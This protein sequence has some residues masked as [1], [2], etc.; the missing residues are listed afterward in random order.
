MGALALGAAKQAIKPTID[1]LKFQ[2][3][4]RDSVVISRRVPSASL[5]EMDDAT[6]LLETCSAPFTLI[7]A[8]HA[9]RRFAQAL[10]ILVAILAID[11]VRRF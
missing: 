11:A 7:A 10:T 6:L 2:M 4:H 8:T 5:I 9:L 1:A 3:A